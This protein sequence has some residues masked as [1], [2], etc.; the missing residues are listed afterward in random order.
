MNVP[1]R[2]PA[3]RPLSLG[4]P[5]AYPA[6][7]SRK[8]IRAEEATVV[9]ISLHELDTLRREI[10]A[11]R[12]VASNRR[13]VECLTDAELGFTDDGM[14]KVGP[15]VT[16]QRRLADRLTLFVALNDDVIDRYRR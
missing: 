10:K 9:D 5:T 1:D 12:E 16:K 15:S 3:G 11:V 2:L 7:V 8:L 6:P 4:S 14:D 13:V